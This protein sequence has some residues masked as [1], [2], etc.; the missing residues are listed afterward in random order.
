MFPDCTRFTNSTL[1]LQ[2]TCNCTAGNLALLYV[3]HRFVVELQYLTS[4]SSPL[5]IS[6]I[7]ALFAVVLWAG[8]PLLAATFLVIAG[9][10]APDWRL[11][12]AALLVVAGLVVATMTR[13]ND[14]LKC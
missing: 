6:I 1:D 9:V 10:A 7:S 4:P 14:A 11:P 2:V 8:A 12:F 13:N 3:I 5:F